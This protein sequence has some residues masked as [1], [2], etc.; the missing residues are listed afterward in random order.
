LGVI[1]DFEIGSQ[2]G[3]L[4]FC[5]LFSPLREKTRSPRRLLAS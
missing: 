4:P 1:L 5:Y 2:R 3:K